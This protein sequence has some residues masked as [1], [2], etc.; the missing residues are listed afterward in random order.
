VILTLALATAAAAMAAGAA[1]LVRRRGPEARQSRQPPIADATAATQARPPAAREPH[2]FAAAVGDVFMSRYGDD[3]LFAGALVLS[4]GAPWGAIMLTETSGDKA[5]FLRATGEAFVLTQASEAWTRTALG[6]G[7]DV[8]TALEHD[9]HVYRRT[10]RIPLNVALVG[11]AA[12]SLQRLAKSSSV[13]VH[14]L[15][16]EGGRVAIAISAGNERAAWTGAALRADEFEIIAP[17]E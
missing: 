7:T 2:G 6:S 9:E 1:A 12:A 14:E 13:V 10:R 8:P 3:L 11:R 5:V 16:A 17:K 15:D 4:E